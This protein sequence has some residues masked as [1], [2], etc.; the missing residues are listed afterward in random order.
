MASTPASEAPAPTPATITITNTGDAQNLRDEDAAGPSTERTEGSAA[1]GGGAAFSKLFSA[2]KTTLAGQFTRFMADT[3]KLCKEM[4]GHLPH[5][6]V[7]L[8][9]G[10]QVIVSPDGNIDM[11][12]SSMFTDGEMR[13]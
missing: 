5:G 10:L 13:A 3:T 1:S 8:P 12:F 11:Q 7:L 9:E 6:K 4:R 2:R